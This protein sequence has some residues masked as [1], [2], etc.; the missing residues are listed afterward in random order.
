MHPSAS[1]DESCLL[2]AT[3]RALELTRAPERSAAVV[4][5]RSLATWSALCLALLGVATV[6][7]SSVAP[8][9]GTW[10]LER[11]TGV[12][13]TCT[14]AAILAATLLRVL[15]G[16]LYG[17]DPRLP[18]LRWL[19]YLRA[20][21]E[22]EVSGLH[23][24]VSAEQVASLRARQGPNIPEAVAETSRLL[25][26]REDL[27]SVSHRVDAALRQGPTWGLSTRSQPPLLDEV[28]RARLL[29]ELEVAQVVADQLPWR[30]PGPVPLP[31]GARRWSRESRLHTLSRG[32]LRL[33]GLAS[34]R[35]VVWAGVVSLNLA[36]LALELGG[37]AL[38]ERT[39]IYGLLGAYLLAEALAFLAESLAA[40]P[41]WHLLR[42]ALHPAV[43]RACKRAAE[44]RRWERSLPRLLR[45]HDE[46]R[47][48]RVDL[49]HE[50]GF[51]DIRSYEDDREQTE[52][53]LWRSLRERVRQAEAELIRAELL[54]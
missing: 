13:L 54:P 17:R 43:E 7:L 15:L 18:S 21:V 1:S 36:G 2:P 30:T 11:L 48:D 10:A 26:L 25:S 45:E 29:S 34:L 53:H 31:P 23:D 20:S 3:R 33:G 39:A 35:A 4:L 51:E 32:L 49:G 37:S 40:R 41:S 16:A 38:P 12:A 14:L 22:A 52:V 6:S 46:R 27:D 24:H 9:V 47:A 44:A 42:E 5:L 28:E 19:A 8:H 50:Q